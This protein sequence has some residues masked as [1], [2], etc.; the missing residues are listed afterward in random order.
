M[1]VDVKQVETMRVAFIR[2]VGPYS[3]VGATWERLMAWAA[4]RGLL[5]P[6][7]TFL[8]ICHDDPDVTPEDKIRYDAGL[9]VDDGFEPEGE[10]GVQ[11]IGGGEYAVTTHFGPYGK[12]GETYARLCGDWLPAHGRELRSAPA[13]EIYLNSPENTDPEDLLTDIHVPLEPQ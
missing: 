7:M 8:G 11:Q 3:E 12:L 2:H 5:G 1:D 4:P 9:V 13:F 6:E 10:V